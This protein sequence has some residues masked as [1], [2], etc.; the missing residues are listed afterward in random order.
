MNGATRIVVVDDHAL[1]R[2]SLVRLLESEVDFRVVAHCDS[3]AQASKI[4]SSTA[5]EL[6]LLDYDLGEESAAGLVRGLKRR[7]QRTKVLVV[8]AGLS[9]A[10][11]AEMLN[12]GVDGVFYKHRDPAQLLKVIRKIAK[13]EP[14]LESAAIRSLIAGAT[15]LAEKRRGQGPLTVRQQEVLS[16]ILSGLSNKE[17]A[18]RLQVSMTTVKT[19]VQELFEKAGVRT[20]GQLV[21]AALQEHAADWL[22]RV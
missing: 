11:T 14:W 15:E 22:G 17:I 4:L 7:A 10:A 8:T 5:I 19:A 18:W 3:V 6:V 1:F 2:E 13:G 9:D 20:R 16:G 12:A 21:R